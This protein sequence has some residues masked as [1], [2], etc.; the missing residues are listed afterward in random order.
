MLYFLL[1][2]LEVDSVQSDIRTLYHSNTD[3]K[4]NQL[5][6]LVVRNPD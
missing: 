5:D 4:R 2:L 3:H 1:K 6:V